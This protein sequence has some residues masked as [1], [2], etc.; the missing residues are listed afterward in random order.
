MISLSEWGVS[1]SPASIS[2]GSLLELSSCHID[3]HNIWRRRLSAKK[4]QLLGSLL[5]KPPIS[6]NFVDM[7]PNFLC[8]SCHLQQEGTFSEWK[9]CLSMFVHQFHE[10]RP[11]RVTQMLLH[12]ASRH[13]HWQQ[14]EVQRTGER[15]QIPAML[16][17]TTLTSNCCSQ[18]ESA[19][20]EHDMITYGPGR[21][22]LA[23]GSGSMLDIFNIDY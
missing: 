3:I 9:L 16:P 20:Y 13:W 12:L 11:L 6:E 1:P 8:E 22:C 21:R 18:I 4:C 23:P 7:Q 10:W 14:L 15:L 2:A 5:N 19:T 17:Y